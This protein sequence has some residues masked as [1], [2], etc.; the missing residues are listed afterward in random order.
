MLNTCA[1]LLE[2]ERL[3]RQGYHLGMAKDPTSLE[4]LITGLFKRT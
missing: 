3:G 4:L 1:L 2:V